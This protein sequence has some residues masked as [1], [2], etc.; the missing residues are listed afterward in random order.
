[1]YGAVLLAS[2]DARKL[3]RINT[4]SYGG[5]YLQV[6]TFLFSHSASAALAISQL[7]SLANHEPLILL[8]P[9]PGIFFP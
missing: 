7:F 8:V 9:Q 4:E 1:M 3:R 2:V 5:D 6:D